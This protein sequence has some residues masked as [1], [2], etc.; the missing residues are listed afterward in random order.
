MASKDG[1]S[2]QPGAGA[3][4]FGGDLYRLCATFLRK[5]GVFLG[6]LNGSRLPGAAELRKRPT[7][8]IEMIFLSIG[9]YPHLTCGCGTGKDYLLAVKPQLG[10]FQVEAGMGRIAESCEPVVLKGSGRIPSKAQ[11]VGIRQPVL[12][13]AGVVRPRFCD[14]RR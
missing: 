3:V 4:S 10:K 8:L 2:V 1:L 14:A 7:F 11:K 6:E 12:Q 5:R 9:V 13:Q